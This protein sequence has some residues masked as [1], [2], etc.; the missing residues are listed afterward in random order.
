MYHPNAYP[1]IRMA[2]QCVHLYLEW[3]KYENFK[4][5][6]IWSLNLLSIKLFIC[7]NSYLFHLPLFIVSTYYAHWPRGGRNVYFFYYF[8]G[9]F[10]VHKFIYLYSAGNFHY[11]IHGA[12]VC[13][14]KQKYIFFIPLFCFFFWIITCI[15]NT[16][17]QTQ[18]YFKMQF[19]MFL[20]IENRT[21]K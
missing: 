14:T 11:I 10:F 9:H 6:T 7:L 17:F 19:I 2:L 12:V 21:L 5:K 20:S 1:N 3:E 16:L 18:R 15:I 4:N 13:S 8:F